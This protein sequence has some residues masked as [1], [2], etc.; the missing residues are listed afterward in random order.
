MRDELAIVLPPLVTVFGFLKAS[1]D[2]HHIGLVF[3]ILP[4]FHGR[5]FSYLPWIGAPKLFKLFGTAIARELN[6]GLILV[7]KGGKLPVDSESTTFVDYS[8]DTKTFEIAKEAVH[9]NEKVLVVDEWSSTGAQLK[10]SISLIEKMGGTISGAT[11]YSM[12]AR[13]KSDPF[14]AKYK[15]H[16]LL[17]SKQ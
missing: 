15:L 7:R 5:V 14:F 6:V 12:N 10:A 17:T 11:C 9:P 8:G 13:V 2:L 16:S 4:G 3:R 1:N